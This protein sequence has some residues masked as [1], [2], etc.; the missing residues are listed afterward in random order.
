MASTGTELAPPE[1]HPTG[2]TRGPREPPEAH[3]QHRHREH[4][5]K[6]LLELPLHP[7]GNELQEVLT[8]KRP[9]QAYAPNYVRP[10]LISINLP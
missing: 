6:L 3:G 10:Q 7:A 2:A 1:P 8:G 9:P 5:P 4:R